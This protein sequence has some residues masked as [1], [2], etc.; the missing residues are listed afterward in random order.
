MAGPDNET[1]DIAAGDMLDDDGSGAGR[2]R[3]QFAALPYR[4]TP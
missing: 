4:L 1:E 2:K 3:L